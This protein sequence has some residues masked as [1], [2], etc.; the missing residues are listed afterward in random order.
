MVN[1]KQAKPLKNTAV[2]NNNDGNVFYVN[3][4]VYYQS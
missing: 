2:Y 1:I 3:N 4:R